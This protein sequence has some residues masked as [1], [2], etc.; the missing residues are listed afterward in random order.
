MIRTLLIALLLTGITSHAQ[1]SIKGSRN[2]TTEQT[3]INSF[4]SIELDGDYEV[5]LLKG[6]R[7]MVEVEADDNLHELFKIEVVDSILY[8]KTSAKITK[9]KSQKLTITYS[10][11]LTRLSLDGKVEFESLQHLYFND[12]EFISKGR[13][14]SKLTATATKFRLHNSDNAKVDLDLTANEI[15]LELAASSDLEGVLKGEALNVRAIDKASAKLNGNVTELILN[16]SKS[17]K[18]D[19][20]K[21]ITSSAEVFA[22][23]NSRNSV[24]VS[25]ELK[26]SAK[27]KSEVD[28]YNTPEIDL[29]EFS[30]KAVLSKKS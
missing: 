13:S 30:E 28:L 19:G 10:D 22:T 15:D 7:T 1:K 5:G 21:L 26:L 2:V 9:S 25:K 23:G 27:D 17:S 18:F 20:E 8:I 3:E 6:N 14:K 11:S 12:F 24:N 16:A 4:K 29:I